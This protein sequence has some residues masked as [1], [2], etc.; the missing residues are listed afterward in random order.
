MKVLPLSVTEADKNVIVT[1]HNNFRRQVAKGLESRGSPGP[2]PSAANMR[3]IV[4]Y[5]YCSNV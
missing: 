5:Y 4:S 1:V 3:E 2:Q